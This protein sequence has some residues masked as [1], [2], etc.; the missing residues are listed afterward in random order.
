MQT[1]KEL[2][3]WAEDYQEWLEREV[4]DEQ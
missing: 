1:D 4:E 2:L 3:Q